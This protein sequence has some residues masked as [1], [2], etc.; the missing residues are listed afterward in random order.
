MLARFLPVLAAQAHRV[1]LAGS[2][3]LHRLF[4]GLPI[5][6]IAPGA[7]AASDPP[8]DLAINQMSLPHVLGVTEDTIPARDGY[9]SV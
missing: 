6:S 8:A 9:L 4:A 2:P 3:S 1:R 5:A 7:V